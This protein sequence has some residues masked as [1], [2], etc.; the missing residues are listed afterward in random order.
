MASVVIRNQNRISEN[1]NRE[2]EFS[3]ENSPFRFFEDS[4][5]NAAG[6]PNIELMDPISTFCD[7]IST[8]ENY[9]NH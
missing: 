6:A 3:Q 7:A 9:Q 4:L 5:Q 2:G 1:R 8:A